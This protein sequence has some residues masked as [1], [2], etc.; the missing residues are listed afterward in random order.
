MYYEYK[1]ET[2]KADSCSVFLVSVFEVLTV[3]KVGAIINFPKYLS[4]VRSVDAS[5]LV[6]KKVY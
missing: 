5:V 2:K 4:L 3:S 6:F 1:T